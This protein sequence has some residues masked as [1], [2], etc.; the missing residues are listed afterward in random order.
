MEYKDMYVLRPPRP[1][2]FFKIEAAYNESLPELRKYMDWA[3]QPLSREKHIERIAEQYARYFL[4]IEYEL[5]LFDKKTD[6]FLFYSGCYPVNRINPMSM[7]IGFWT[8]T[9]HAGKGYASLSTKMLIALIFEYLKGDRIEITSNI[10]NKASL[11]V[12]EK[13]GFVKEGTLRNFYPKGSI[14]MFKEGYTPE[15]KVF[16]FSLIPEDRSML[17][18]YDD[19]LSTC[20][21]FPFLK[22][23]TPLGSLLTLS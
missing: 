11:R 15:R 2:D 18:W 9:K 20:L 16:M 22:E 8:P 12:I 19:I 5:A 17:P 10:E 6:E 3:H 14:E 21:V 13:C 1:E 4:G 23:P 7:E